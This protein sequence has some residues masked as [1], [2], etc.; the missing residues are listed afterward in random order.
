[1][2][3]RIKIDP[4]T[5]YTGIELKQDVPERRRS[6]QAAGRHQTG[7][8][9]AH[10]YLKPR[11]PKHPSHLISSATPTPNPAS[12]IRPVALNATTHH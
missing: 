8:A 2:H 9:T 12:M 4:G 7:A 1:M 11:R 6:L 3:Q 5:I 10:E